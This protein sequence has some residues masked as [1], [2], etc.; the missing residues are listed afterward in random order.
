MVEGAVAAKLK[1]LEERIVE[2][3]RKAKADLEKLLE[4]PASPAPAAP[5]APPAEYQVGG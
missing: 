4:H 3:E 2:L 1:E 5:A